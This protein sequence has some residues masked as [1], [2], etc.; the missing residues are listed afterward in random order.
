VKVFVSSPGDLGDARAIVAHE[1]E[2]FNKRKTIE[3]KL[4]FSAYLYEER[5]PAAIGDGPQNIVDTE[6][7][8][9]HDADVVICMFRS[10]FGTPLQEINPDTGKPYGSGTEYEFFDA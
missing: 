5:T 10:R 3:N 2:K 7:L 8:P 1:I 4:V 6:M 9:A